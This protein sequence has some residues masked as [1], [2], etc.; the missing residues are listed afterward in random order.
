M[1]EERW[2]GGRSKDDESDKAYVPAFPTITI[3]NAAD[4]FVRIIR[5]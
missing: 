2:A 1:A 5:Q 3:V 4:G